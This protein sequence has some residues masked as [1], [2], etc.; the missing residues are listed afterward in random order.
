M[1]LDFDSIASQDIVALNVSNDST[2]DNSTSRRTEQRPE[3]QTRRPRTS[4]IAATGST[5]D[6]LNKLRTA[7]ESKDMDSVI[8][9]SETLSPG[10]IQF[11][12]RMF[13]RYDRLD[14]VIDDVDN[15]GNS[16]SAKLNV[17]MFNRSDDG[18]FYTAG[19]WSGVTLNVDQDQGIW[20]KIDW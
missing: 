10:R 4:F 2:I 17:S 13:Q 11:L 5:A 19:K 14:V 20:Q 8:S 3:T 9:I 16:A 6:H 18:S 15:N 7:L 1:A 12:S